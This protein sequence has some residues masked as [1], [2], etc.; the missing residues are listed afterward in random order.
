M[1]RK[2]G[3][4]EVRS[5]NQ[6]MYIEIWVFSTNKHEASGKWSHE[7]LKE[8]SYKVKFLSRSENV[9]TSQDFYVLLRRIK[10][11]K[12]RLNSIMMFHMRH[13]IIITSKHGVHNIRFCSANLLAQLIRTNHTWNLCPCSTSQMNR[14]EV[15]ITTGLNHWSKLHT[16]IVSL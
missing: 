16:S 12:L 4:Y 9:H 3:T 13:H 2:L 6:K 15:L 8:C 1:H 5:C 10:V 7:N 14:L 11:E